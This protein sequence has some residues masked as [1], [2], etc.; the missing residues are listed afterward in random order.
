MR[1][2]LLSNNKIFFPFNNDWK[3][4]EKYS[5]I[6]GAIKEMITKKIIVNN[7]S[8]LLKDNDHFK[9]VNI[10]LKRWYANNNHDV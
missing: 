7:W 9:Q 2:E 8:N 1:L 6:P 10:I 5:K 4:S 3:R